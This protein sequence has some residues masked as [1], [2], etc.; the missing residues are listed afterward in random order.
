MKNKERKLS[1]YIDKLNA[2][3]KPE[4]HGKPTDK[5]ELEKLCE[6]VRKVR[7]L[8][9]PDMPAGDYPARL[10]ASVN[11]GLIR[12]NPENNKKRIWLTGMAGVAAI[13]VMAV[14]LNSILPF[15]GAS[16]V[17]AMEEAFRE[18][19]AYHGTLEI[20]QTNAKGEQSLQAELEVWANKEGYYYIKGLEGWQKGIVTAN[21]GQR[22]WQVRPDREEVHV[23]PAF[24]D[25]YRFTFELGKEI[26][27]VKNA[28]SAKVVGEDTVAGRKADILEI[29][30][31]NGRAYRIWVDKETKL[32]LQKQSAMQ[33]ALQ[34]TITYTQIDFS[35]SIPDEFIAYSVPY[36]YKEIDTNPEQLVNSVEEVREIIGFNPRPPESIP[37]GFDQDGIAVAPGAGLSKL[38]YLE[39]D[40]GDR[41]IVVQ[42]RPV[43]EFNAA[44]TAVLGKADNNIAEIQSPVYED[45]GILGGG[46]LYAGIT[47]ISSI[48]WRQD[49][50]EYAVVGSAPLEK[51]AVFV[52]SLTG[53]SFEMPSADDQT[54][55]A[56]RIEVPV[57]LEVEQSSQ[58]GVDAGS[59]PWRLD[60]AFVAQVFVSLE[61]SPGGITGE[62]PVG[63]EELEVIRNNGK[64][65]VVEV[66]GDKTPIRRVYLKR[67]I[68]QDSTGIWTVI[69]YDPSDNE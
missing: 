38:Y 11:K 68:R 34:Y 36:G 47:D 22:K 13:L 27:Q 2:G 21:N 1:E 57:D 9:E 58:K 49:G 40:K 65:A 33:N 24:P 54:S 5:S 60:P 55:D 46:A 64:D 39:Q 52:H 6:T 44:P 50:Y 45:L 67:L 17:H 61:M 26:Q 51:L 53:G 18:V 59:S 8:K 23:F 69:G 56:P 19:K 62:Y 32:P 7:S 35:G 31:H 66:S 29:S 10:A 43:G 30:P 48:R 63:Y 42:G 28:L 4:Q 15:G 41:V 20:V 16:I 25:A 12:N 14:M 3:Q 37:A